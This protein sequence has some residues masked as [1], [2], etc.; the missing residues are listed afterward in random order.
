MTA[1]TYHIL[2]K[3]KIQ[4]TFLHIFYTCVSGFF[5][6]L[7]MCKLIFLG[8]HMCMWI[9]WFT[10]MCKWIFFGLHI[11]T[12]PFLHGHETKPN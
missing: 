2:K 11:L 7:H 4:N 12:H 10:H 5:L 3:H 8:L 9:F 6:G 1:K